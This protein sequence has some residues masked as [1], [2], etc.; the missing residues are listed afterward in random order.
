MSTIQV[1][2]H[3]GVVE[4][5]LDRPAEKNAMNDEM[6]AELRTDLRVHER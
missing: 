4:V 6:I 5:T 1:D 3:D 2:G